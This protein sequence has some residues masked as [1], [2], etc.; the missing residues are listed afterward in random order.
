MTEGT[1]RTGI[2]GAVDP[3]RVIAFD[4]SGT[5]SDPVVVGDDTGD[6]PVFR[7]PVPEIPDSHPAALA[8]V[9]LDGYAGFET[10]APIGAVVAEQGVPTRP[11]LSNVA[12]TPQ[13]VREAVLAD[14]TVPARTVAR[15]VGELTAETAGEFPDGP[16]VGVQLV[17]DL[18][19]GRV[20]RVLAYTT[21]PRAVSA[22]VVAAARAAGY[23]PHI[24]SGDA[25]HILRAV[26]ETVAVPPANVHPYQSANDKAETL[27]GLPG[28]VERTVMVGDYVNDRFAL[29]A[30]DLGILID[31]GDATAALVAAADHAV[32][33]ID[34]VPELLDD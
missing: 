30:A 5:L 2:S 19:A 4:N 34:H 18:D 8:S 28:P 11:A 21:V 23:E 7:Q 13:A 33:A 24:V 32:P 22:D 12:T 29:E 20:H 6:D 16:P 1:E 3:R 10:D 14:T 15:V 26:A 31:D 9:V 17:V 25:D 27:A